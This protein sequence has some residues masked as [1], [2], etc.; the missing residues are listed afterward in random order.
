MERLTTL[1]QVQTH[2]R[3]GAVVDHGCT[4]DLDTLLSESLQP[5]N[6]TYLGNQRL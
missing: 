1:R 4:I 6:P 3:K 2:D 5:P